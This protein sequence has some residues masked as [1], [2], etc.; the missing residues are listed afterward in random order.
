MSYFENV[1]LNETQLV[2]ISIETLEL[3]DRNGQEAILNGSHNPKRITGDEDQIV[4]GPIFVKYQQVFNVLIIFLNVNVL[5]L[6]DDELEVNF[7]VRQLFHSLERAFVHT[8]LVFFQKLFDGFVQYRFNM[9][10]DVLEDFM[11]EL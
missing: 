9:V 5:L 6:M 7:H 11:M 3:N 4:L 1:V 2:I 8:F 10:D